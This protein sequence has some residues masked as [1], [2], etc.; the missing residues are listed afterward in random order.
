MKVFKVDLDDGKSIEKLKDGK[1]NKIKFN[2]P[3]AALMYLYSLG[4]ELYVNN[5]AINKNNVKKHV[6]SLKT[7]GRNLVPFAPS[8]P[9]SSCRAL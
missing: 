5:R 7:F 4:W 1:G 3:A 9:K 2:T 8:K 6:E